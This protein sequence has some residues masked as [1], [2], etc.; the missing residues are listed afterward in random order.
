MPDGLE[1]LV[2]RE[3]EKVLNEKTIPS[4][5]RSDGDMSEGHGS[6]QGKSFQ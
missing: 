4:P 6:T 1:H 2:M 5:S 3:S